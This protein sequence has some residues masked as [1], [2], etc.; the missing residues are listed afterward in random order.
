MPILFTGANRGIGHELTRQYGASGRAVIATTRRDTPADLAG[1][2]D[3]RTLDVTDPASFTA[4][5]AG[6][7]G[8]KLSLLV[9]NAGV[10]VDKGQDLATGYSPDLWEKS[11]AANVMGPF[12]TVQSFLPNLKAH[13]A[14]KIAIVASQM[15]ANGLAHGSRLGP[16]TPVGSKPIWAAELLI[17]TLR[18]PRQ[19]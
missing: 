12:L 6:L 4:L 5:G 7:Y 3:W 14:G 15:G 13:G 10:Y 17:L 11:F 8:Q 19:A 1:Q 9:C 16:I 2:A 18:L